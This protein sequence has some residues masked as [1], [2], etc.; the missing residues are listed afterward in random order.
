VDEPTVLDVLRDI[1]FTVQDMQAA[2]AQILGELLDLAR[3]RNEELISAGLTLATIE[4]L[5]DLI[6]DRVAA[7]NPTP[8]DDDEVG[9]DG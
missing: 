6:D 1:L 5:L 3:D 2:Q 4:S 7:L 9:E 8:P